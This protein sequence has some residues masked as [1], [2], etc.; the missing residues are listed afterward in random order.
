MKRFL[1][2]LA[3]AVILVSVGII[4]MD[5]KT[6]T[7]TVAIDPMHDGTYVIGGRSVTLKSGY[8]EV[9][10]LGSASKTIT[11]YFGNDATGDINGDGRTDRAFLITQEMG[12][13]GTF[14]Y[15]VGLLDTPQG[16]AGTDGVLLGDRIA[17]Q[18]TSIDSKGI[19][20]VNYAD[21]KVTDSFASPAT[22]GKS[23]YLKLDPATLQ[24]G[25]V[26]QGFE[27]EA[28]PSH[29]SLQMKKWNWVNTI[30]GDGKEVKPL[31][32]NR[33]SLTFQSNGKFSATTDCNG[34]GGSFV[35]N[36]KTLKFSNMVSTLIGCGPSQERAFTDMLTQTKSYSFT[37]KG[38]L[39]MNL[40]LNNGAFI[41]R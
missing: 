14:F 28:D 9:A 17:P 21:R 1:A 3:F 16:K 22:E 19:V 33:F 36:E 12:G 27:G 24:F 23:L 35:S 41:F 10:N 39:I 29:M 13:S 26:V 8:S 38:E 30:Y 7:Q 2:G 37:S 11:R 5:D 31:Q 15:V 4:W 25:E 18:N 32:A 40:N 20:L 6:A 34:I